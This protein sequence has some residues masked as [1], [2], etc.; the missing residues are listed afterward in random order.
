MK[1]INGLVIGRGLLTA[2]TIGGVAFAATRGSISVTPLSS[3]ASYLRS[4]SRMAGAPSPSPRVSGRAT[5]QSSL[6]SRISGRIRGA[7]RIA[8]G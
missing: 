8:M 5:A 3:W 7:V 6:T 1:R 4:V 2:G